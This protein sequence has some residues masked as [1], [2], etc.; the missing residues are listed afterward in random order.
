MQ[1][2]LQIPILEKTSWS[3]AATNC[4]ETVF[5]DGLSAIPVYCIILFHCFTVPFGFL[6]LKSLCVSSGQAGIQDHTFD[7]Q[8]R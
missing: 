7:K 3:G 8:D 4:I 1:G 2:P 6:E 5:C